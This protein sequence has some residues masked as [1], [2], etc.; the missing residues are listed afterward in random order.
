MTPSVAIFDDR[1]E[2]MNPGAFPPGTT[3]EEFRKRPHSL[4][5][6]EKIAGALFKGGKAEGWGRGI[7]NIFTYCKEAGLPE[8]EYD[9]VTHFVCLTIRF[10]APLTPHLTNQDNDSS[11]E[12]L[13]ETLNATLNPALL[14]TYEL[15][16]R[17]PGIQRKDLII[18]SGCVASTI[19][20]H[21][22]VLIEKG[23]IERRGYK[24]TGG[25]YIK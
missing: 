6:N 24:K 10:K 12:T 23:L 17:T 21:I 9:F 15:I 2:F 13:N 16:K 20:R 25:Y 18:P 8:P 22:A 11:K 4:P 5:I 19:S 14:S 7:L 3:P 1:I